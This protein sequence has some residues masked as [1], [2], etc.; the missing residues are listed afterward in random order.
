[1]HL[2]RDGSWQCHFVVIE[3]VTKRGRQGATGVG[4][5]KMVWPDEEVLDCCERSLLDLRRTIQYSFCSN[6]SWT[7]QACSETNIH[8]V[9]ILLFAWDSAFCSLLAW[10][11]FPYLQRDGPNYT[12]F[13]QTM[14]FLYISGF[15]GETKVL[16]SS[17]YK[18]DL[19]FFRVF[20][21]P[22]SNFASMC[23]HVMFPTL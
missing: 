22:S 9:A 6:I 8:F 21:I 4:C 14:I 12:R 20:S 17:L 10:E 23:A 1:M 18:M 5:Y 7:L 11:T 15:S 3:L 2:C 16:S 19:C 13:I